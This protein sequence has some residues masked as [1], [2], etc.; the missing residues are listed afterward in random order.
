M[1]TWHVHLANGGDLTVVAQQCLIRSGV[2]SFRILAPSNTSDPEPVIVWAF[3]QHGWLDA[4]LVDTPYSAAV[5][6]SPAPID[7]R[8]RW[9]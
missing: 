7:H 6:P 4:T 2:L 8:L 3:G 9:R 5:H 1:R